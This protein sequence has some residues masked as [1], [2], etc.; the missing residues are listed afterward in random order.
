[1]FEA[2]DLLMVPFP[3]TD[4][5]SAKRRPVLALTAPDA[6]GDF[7]GC[8]ITSRGHWTHSRPLL[9]A[10]LTEGSLPLQSWVRT[11]RVVTLHIGLVLSTI[12]RT[13]KEFRHAVA[14]DVCRF[15]RAVPAVA[16]G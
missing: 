1:M 3:F 12:G 11:D 9:P 15:I 5:S 10:D 14:S 2:G 8:P 13:S 6:Q 4:Q 16:N 7:I